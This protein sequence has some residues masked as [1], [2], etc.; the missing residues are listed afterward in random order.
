MENS[1]EQ[2]QEEQ[3]K[4]VAQWLLASPGFFE[5]HPNLLVNLA[6][7]NSHE[8]KAISLQEKQMAL[9]RNQNRDLNDKLAQMLRF[10]TENDRTQTL[11]VAWLEEL[12]LARTEEQATRSITT[13]LDRLFAIGEVQI[14]IN[15]EMPQTLKDRLASLPV[16]G[17]LSM[18]KDLIPDSQNILEGSIAMIPLQVEQRVLGVLVLRSADRT[19][20]SA[21]MGLVYIQQFG[22]LASAALYR[23]RKD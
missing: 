14:L 22:R 15:S 6:L 5:R 8:G 3:E 20:F 4:L 19:K 23:F 13:G 16:C 2:T 11:M 21:E 1:P 12:L 10:G 17:D 18:A 7:T 9:L